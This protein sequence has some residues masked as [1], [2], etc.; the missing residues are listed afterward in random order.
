MPKVMDKIP[1]PPMGAYIPYYMGGVKE[2][3]YFNG[4]NQ[5]GKY[6]SFAASA[7]GN[8]PFEVNFDSSDPIPPESVFSCFPHSRL[9]LSY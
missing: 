6:P 4:K 9:T 1:N 5:I 7:V 3:W 8:D 2:P